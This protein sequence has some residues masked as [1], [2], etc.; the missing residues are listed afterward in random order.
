MC[1]VATPFKGDYVLLR[2]NAKYKKTHA[3][4]SDQ[5]IVFADIVKKINRNNGKVIFSVIYLQEKMRC[6]WIL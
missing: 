1:S 2:N 6:C 4:T 5:F 3:E